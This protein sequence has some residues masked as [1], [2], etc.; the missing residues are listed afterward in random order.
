MIWYV[1][2][3]CFFDLGDMHYILC[4]SYDLSNSCI[5]GIRECDFGYGNMVVRMELC[6]VLIGIIT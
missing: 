2:V 5:G 6:I 3:F 1:L 4:I